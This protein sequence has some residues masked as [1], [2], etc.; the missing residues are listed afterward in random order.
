M[1]FSPTHH[2]P[3]VGPSGSPV[4]L[5]PYRILVANYVTFPN[6]RRKPEM[7]LANEL[8][9]LCWAGVAGQPVL[10]PGLSGYLTN[11]GSQ[12]PNQASPVNCPV[13]LDS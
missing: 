7:N 9:Q 4:C 2:G 5:G 10:L 8:F 3:L 12:L 1:L 6:H 13:W 11:C